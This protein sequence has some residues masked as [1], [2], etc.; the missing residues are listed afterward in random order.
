MDMNIA[1]TAIN[2]NDAVFPHPAD[3]VVY[4]IA[5]V[6]VVVAGVVVVVAGHGFWVGPVKACDVTFTQKLIRAS[7]TVALKFKINN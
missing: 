4:G 3:G 7:T 6:V 2:K 5:G 1:M